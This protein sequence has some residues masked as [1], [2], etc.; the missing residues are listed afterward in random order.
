MSHDPRPSQAVPGLRRMTPTRRG[1]ALSLLLVLVGAAPALAADPGLS[2]SGSV[3][4]SRGDYGTDADTTIVYAPLTLRVS[5]TDRLTLGV[6]VPYIRQTTQNVVVTG[7][8]VAV[9]KGQERR[10]EE[11]LGDVLLKGEYVLLREGLILPEVAGS[12]KIKFPTADEDRGLGT[13]EFDETIGVSFSKTFLQ[14]L[15]G[16]LDLGYTFVGSPPGA[17]FDNSFSWSVGAAYLLAEPLTLFAFLEGATAISRG[18]DDP[19]DLR[20]GAEYK[21]TKVVRL[22][23]SGTIGLSEGSA[24]YGVSAGLAFRF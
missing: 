4:Y 8:G 10:T 12:V 23:G 7:G 22:T 19:L 18:Q 11:G 16:Y 1:I 5:P 2:L 21:L 20:L 14:R 9:R 6:T 3:E 15:V 13:G 24:D 17:D